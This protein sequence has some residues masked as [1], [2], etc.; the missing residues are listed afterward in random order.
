MRLRI[1]PVDVLGR[2]VRTPLDTRVDA[3]DHSL[4]V[5]LRGLAS[6][7]YFYRVTSDACSVTPMLQVVQ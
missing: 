3:G 5:D 4:P 1:V 2:Y 7:T 6:G